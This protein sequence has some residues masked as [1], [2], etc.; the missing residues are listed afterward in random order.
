MSELQVRGHTA[1]STTALHRHAT[2]FRFALAGVFALTLLGAAQASDQAVSTTLGFA[3]AI[4]ILAAAFIGW[5][6]QVADAE[7]AGLVK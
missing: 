1:A 5:E 6:R 2:A 4:T 7:S 3:T